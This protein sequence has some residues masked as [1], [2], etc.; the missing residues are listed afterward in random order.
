MQ[1]IFYSQKSFPEKTASK[2]RYHK[3]NFPKNGKFLKAL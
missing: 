1:K 3:N 2:N